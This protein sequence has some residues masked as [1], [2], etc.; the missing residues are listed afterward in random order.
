MKITDR[1]LHSFRSNSKQIGGALTLTLLAPFIVLLSFGFLYPILQLLATGFLEPHLTF[2]NYHKVFT[3]P[4][5]SR[6]LFRTMWIS[7]TVAILALMLAYP[8]AY[9]MARAKGAL[10][11]I[12]AC[13]VILPLWSSVLVRTAAWAILLQREGIINSIIVWAG[14]SEHPVRLLYTQAAVVIAMTHVL[15]PFMVLP[16]YGS[17]RN[18]PED[19]LRSA[20]TMGA[21]PTRSFIEVMLPL[22]LPGVSTGF[23]LVFLTSLGFFV[24]P[25]ILGSPREMMIATL[26][27]Q[28]IREFLNWPLAAALVGVLVIIVLAITLLFARSIRFD[29]LMEGHG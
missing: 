6:V 21:S 19:Y 28:Q 4:T 17:I 27:S 24:T 11:I 5:Y 25:A 20:A 2:D 1:F 3:N 12:I 10:P 7:L 26:I 9:L 18:I 16:I 8:T 22:S 29:K 15:M 13:C 14:I 23:I